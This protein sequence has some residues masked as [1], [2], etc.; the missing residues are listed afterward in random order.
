MNTPQ[1]RFSKTRIIVWLVVGLLGFG[2]L[3]VFAAAHVTKARS[4]SCANACVNNLRQID[5]A[6][7]QFALEH[8]L[9]NGAPIHYPGDLTPYIKLNSAGKIPPCPDGGT[10]SVGK[11]G[12]APTCSLGAKV[13]PAHILW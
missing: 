13:Q 7:N 4:T 10:Y 12:D 3:A 1:K 9:T 2:L 6:I 5:A 11:L 8:S